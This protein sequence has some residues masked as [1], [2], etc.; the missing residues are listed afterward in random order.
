MQCQGLVLESFWF[1][2]QVYGLSLPLFFCHIW[3]GIMDYQLIHKEDQPVALAVHSVAKSLTDL[4]KDDTM[5]KALQFWRE[6][7]PSVQAAAQALP[8][9]CFVVAVKGALERHGAL[10]EDEFIKKNLDPVLKK[11]GSDLKGALD[12]LVSELGLNDAVPPFMSNLV[13]G[14]RAVH[15]IGDGAEKMASM[16]PNP[17]DLQKFLPVY[18]KM[19]AALQPRLAQLL[20]EQASHFQAACSHFEDGLMKWLTEVTHTM[21]HRNKQLDKFRPDF[22]S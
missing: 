5:G 12:Y 9:H 11:F 13:S 14:L 22:H 1:S 8:G 20:P 19:K 10:M 15:S 3:A 17:E 2:K 16:S 18:I 6:I 7:R 21:D 4:V